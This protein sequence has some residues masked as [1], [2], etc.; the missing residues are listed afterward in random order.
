[1]ISSPPRS[2]LLQIVTED[3]TKTESERCLFPP[4]FCFQFLKVISF[5]LFLLRHGIHRSVRH[6]NSPRSPLFYEYAREFCK[7]AMATT[8]DDSTINQ[9]LWLGA[10][11]HHPVDLQD[12]TLG[13][14][15][16]RARTSPTAV[17]SS[18]KPP[19]IRGPCKPAAVRGQRKSATRDQRKPA[20]RCW[21]KPSA[22]PSKAL[23]SACASRAPSSADPS[24]AICSACTPR[25]P[26]SADPSK[27]ICSACTPRVPSSAGPSKALCHACAPQSTHPP[28]HWMFYGVRHAC[29]EGERG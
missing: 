10:N 23:C 22:S 21:L 1:M 27:A 2:L 3:R 4:V 17:R 20:G 25:A 13:S 12:T 26:S 16:A 14:V 6:P 5:R 24:K 15:R 29:W 9:L 19:S 18:R 8:E 28:P 11:Y 7:L